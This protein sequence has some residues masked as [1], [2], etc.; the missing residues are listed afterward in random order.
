MHFA[1]ASGARPAIRHRVET[2]DLDAFSQDAQAAKVSNA[3][4]T[5]TGTAAWLYFANT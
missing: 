5:Q 2:V 3:V 4:F 1:D